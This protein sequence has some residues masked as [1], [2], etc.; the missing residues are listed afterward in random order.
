MAWKGHHESSQQDKG[1]RGH[2]DDLSSAKVT[3]GATVTSPGR[4]THEARPEEREC[5]SDVDSESEAEEFE[6]RNHGQ[7]VSC[8][9]RGE[10]SIDDMDTDDAAHSDIGKPDR[11]DQSSSDHGNKT[12]DADED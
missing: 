12:E 6:W 10:V 2:S 4:P 3:D 11:S 1:N 9:A 8:V 5:P 7:F